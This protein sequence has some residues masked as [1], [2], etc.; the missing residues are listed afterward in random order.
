MLDPQS[1]VSLCLSGDSRADIFTVKSSLRAYLYRL[2]HARP[3]HTQLQGSGGLYPHTRGSSSL[4]SFTSVSSVTST[5]SAPS[6]LSRPVPQLTHPLPC[7]SFNT[8]N[9]PPA[10][11]HPG[12]CHRADFTCQFYSIYR[13]TRQYLLSN[14]LS[15]SSRLSRQSRK[16]QKN[17]FFSWTYDKHLRLIFVLVV[18]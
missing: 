2:T 6:K 5:S 17:T 7:S 14:P 4:V 15:T 1:E 13:P 11:L 9:D 18:Y 12:N 10:A 3:P 16:Y 8:V